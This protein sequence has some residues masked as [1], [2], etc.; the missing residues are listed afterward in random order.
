MRI[1]EADSTGNMAEE[2]ISVSEAL[3]L[4]SPFSGNKREV[5]TFISNVDT[6]IVQPLRK[7]CLFW[8]FGNGG[9]C[10]QTGM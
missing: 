10:R 9:D 2:Y 8:K 6:V 7:L 3:K 5:L 4:V 1:L